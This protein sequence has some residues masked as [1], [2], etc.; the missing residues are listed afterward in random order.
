M[1]SHLRSTQLFEVS[2]LYGT[3]TL[4]AALDSGQFG[5]YEDEE[6]PHR[7]LLVSN[8][9]AIP[10]TAVQLSEMDGFAALADRFDAVVDWNRE[11]APHHPSQWTPEEQDA[12]L[13][14]RMFRAS[15]GLG[16]GPLEL[17]VESVTAAPAKALAA[18]FT[19]AALH[20][21]ADGLMSYGPTRD[22][23]PSPLARRIRRLLHLD[24]VPGL[25][26]LLFT[27]HGV[28]A[29]LVPHDAFRKVLDEIA[30]PV[31]IRDSAGEAPTAV[32][33][34]QYLAALNILT[35]QE[36]ED[37]LAGM[38]R[39]AAAAGHTSVLFKPHPTAPARQSLALERAAAEAGARL[40][41]VRQPMLAE[42]LYGRLAP[43]LVVGC[44][45]TAMITA[46]RLYGLPVARSG[47]ELLLLRLRPFQNSNRVPVTIIDALVPELGAPAEVPDPDAARTGELQALL[48]TVGFCMQ[49]GRMRDLRPQA[50]EWLR[51]ASGTETARYIGRGR[52]TRLGLPGGV[53]RGPVA[54]RLLPA[55]RRARS[56]ARKV[57][58][59]VR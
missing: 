32:V 20:V 56:V 44:F 49:P 18:I 51:A 41:V 45:S 25:S 2:T 11:I 21:Y 29:E 24:L 3:A 34:G 40:T 15:W 30:A 8:N 6:T 22:P 19:D 36:E 38:V 54:R 12:P 46:S 33:L 10:E 13:W 52:L 31:D 1:Y 7:V 9:A 14:Q 28:P 47:T 26:P 43:R 53:V 42:A 48:H 57:R 59:G 50:E 23:L 27:E 4:A 17:V 35:Q 37:M 55:A 58:N 16:E 39:G 5:P